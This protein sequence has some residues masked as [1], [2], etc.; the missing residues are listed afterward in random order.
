MCDN[1]AYTIPLGIFADEHELKPGE[2][3]EYM[4]DSQNTMLNMTIRLDNAN[5]Y[6][7]NDSVSITLIGYG[8]GFVTKYTLTSFRYGVYIDEIR[9]N[10]III[11]TDIQE[12]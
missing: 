9:I 12:H 2:S 11:T 5:S 3:I 7:S 8:R 4:Y 10:K 6:P 1:M